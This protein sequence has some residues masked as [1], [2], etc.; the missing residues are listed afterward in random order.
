MQLI[1]CNVTSDARLDCLRNKKTSDIMYGY[2]EGFF[3]PKPPVDFEPVFAPIFGFGPV[4]DGTTK[5]VPKLP[6]ESIV[7]GEH[8]R[9]V[10]FIAGTNSNE[11]SIFISQT[12]IVIPN[13]SL[14]LQD[15]MQSQILHTIMDARVGPEVID[16][17]MD[18]LLN[19]QY[20]LTELD[21]V[22]NQISKI[23]RDYIFTC[24]TRRALRWR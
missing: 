19:T 3:G 13:V 11:G 4:I 7:K 15:G 21:T 9:D 8:N 16:A 20:P 6:Y 5:G 23:L 10:R 24:A 22:D 14:P 1:G 17:H 2:L 18:E 12:P